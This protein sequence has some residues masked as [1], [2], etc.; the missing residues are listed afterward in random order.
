MCDTSARRWSVF[1]D[2]MQAIYAVRLDLTPAALKEPGLASEA[3]KWLTMV[4]EKA[5]RLAENG[6]TSGRDRASVIVC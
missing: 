6:Q 5:I 3:N 4:F 1:F 2:I